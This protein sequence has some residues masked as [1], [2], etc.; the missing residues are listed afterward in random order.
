MTVDDVFILPAG[1][2]ARMGERRVVFIS[3][4]DHFHDAEVEIVASDDRYA[5][6]RYV[7]G[8]SLFPGQT[9]VQTG[10]YALE[11]ALRGEVKQ[12]AHAGHSH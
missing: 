9:V 10:A 4:G 11:I 7:Q 2:I 12:D 3:E 1:A 6:V 5:I 8:S